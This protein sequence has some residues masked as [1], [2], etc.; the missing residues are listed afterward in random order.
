MSHLKKLGAIFFL[1]L[2]SISCSAIQ[3]AISNLLE[4][5][6]DFANNETDSEL[7]EACRELEDFFESNQD[8]LASQTL[9]L[10]TRSIGNNTNI[11]LLITDATGS[12]IT[13]LDNVTIEAAGSSDAG[14]NFTELP[15]DQIST[16][17]ELAESEANTDH[18]SLAAV[19]DYSGSVLDDDLDFVTDALSL[20]F[21]N[22]DTSYRGEV[23]KFSTEVQVTQSF[24]SDSAQL[25]AAVQDETFER[26]LTSLFDGLMQAIADTAEETTGLKLAILFTDGLD[27]DS[28]ATYEQVRTL[29]QNEGI[30][31]CVV[32]VG[33]ADV[34]LLQ[35]I[36]DDSG[37]FF[38]YRALF[39]DLE[40]AFG[41]VVDQI[42]KLY[43][44]RFDSDDLNGL[45]TLR[46]SITTD[47][48]LREL[49]IPL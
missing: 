11:A 30:P 23:V 31:V 3:G 38:I 9:A 7:N 2:F 18:L 40:D 32:G 24:T 15:I 43:R 49:D 19:I 42:E 28:S 45:D 33:F 5:C 4:N 6:E 48:G 35:Q 12:P 29:F 44:I 17:G 26:S 46:L 22:L 20:L 39:A 14:Q 37:C 41:T 10:S 16:Y 47:T 8:S 27:N 34:D 25:L 36:A 13:G 1:A 21:E